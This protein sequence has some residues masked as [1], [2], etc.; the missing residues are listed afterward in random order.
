M[1]NN[2]I[3]PVE[4][5]DNAIVSISNQISL[6][7]KL[8]ANIER[9]KSDKV[10]QPID[11]I[12]LLL[13]ISVLEDIKEHG[14]DEDKE[15]SHV[16]GTVTDIDG[17][18]YHTVKI[19]T[20]WWMIENLKTSHYRDGSAI[21]EIMDSISWANAPGSEK[22]AW[23]YYD[24][25]AKNNAA[26][27]K[28]Y[29]WYAVAD[30]RGLCPAGWHVPSEDEFHLLVDYL[31]GPKVAGGKMKA[32]TLWAVPNTGADNSI[33]ST[34]LPAGNRSHD[35]DG[36]YYFSNLGLSRYFWSSTEDGSTNA[37]S[38]LIGISSSMDWAS[39]PKES[40][41]SVLCIAD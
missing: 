5:S 34:A 16:T 2:S 13:S 11:L 20:Q 7:N 36:S 31:G 4:P 18:L 14:G 9:D 37:C 40:G 17:N 19:G 15:L 6:T 12:G 38:R 27:G 10:K 26:Y 41:L 29:N 21:T 22:A 24:N 23:C 33:D 25:N 32:L 28:L 35:W 30:P 1:E 39:F 8:L 3:V